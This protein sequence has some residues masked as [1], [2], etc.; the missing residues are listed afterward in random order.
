MAKPLH[1]VSCELADSGDEALRF[2]VDA[3]VAARVVVDL[4]GPDG[5]EG[6]PK[7]T[8]PPQG[9]EARILDGDGDAV[10]V[11]QSTEARGERDE[12]LVHALPLGMLLVTPGGDAVKGARDGEPDGPK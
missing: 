9:G 12:V 1:S 2:F 11:A 3:T 5:G 10:R 6:P 8:S 4:D 7:V